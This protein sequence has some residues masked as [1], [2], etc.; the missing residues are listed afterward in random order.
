MQVEDFNPSQPVAVLDI[1]SVDDPRAL[2][3]GGEGP[4]F[5]GT[6]ETISHAGVLDGL[7]EWVE[8]NDCDGPDVTEVSTVAS[9]DDEQVDR[10]VWQGCGVPVEHLRIAGSGHGWP[11]VSVGF[12]VQRLLGPPTELINASDEVWAFAS[13]FER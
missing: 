10:I 8:A 5:P 12:V 2:Y 9:S 6:Q 3:E 4:P 1:H 11:G 7:Y 13:Q